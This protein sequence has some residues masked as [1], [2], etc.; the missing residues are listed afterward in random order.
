MTLRRSWELLAGT[1]PSVP[2]TQGRREAGISHGLSWVLSA[3]EKCHRGQHPPKGGWV[4][5]QGEVGSPIP[6]LM[7][8]SFNSLESSPTEME[9]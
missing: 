9:E 4:E 3:T 1:S 7:D 8:R 5:C 2:S 6:L